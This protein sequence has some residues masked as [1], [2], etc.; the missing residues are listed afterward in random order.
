M[1]ALTA[2]CVAG[3]PK[4]III[5]PGVTMPL[6]NL[7]GVSSR[8]SNYSAWLSL[9]GRGLDTAL[10]YGDATQQAVAAA[11]SA[12]TV[13]RSEIFVTSKVPCCHSFPIPGLSHDC[14]TPEFNGTALHSIQE[15]VAILGKLD[16][17]LLHWPCSTLEGTLAAYADLEKALE[18][19]LTRAI[20]VSNFNATTLAAMLPKVKTQPAVNQCGHSVGAHNA[21]HNP[22]LGGDDATVAF[23]AA[24]NIAY[25]AYSPLGGLN[26]LDI[27]NNPTVKRIATAHSVSPAQVALRWLIQQDPPISIVTAADTPE[28]CAED[29]DLF[30][31]ELTAAEMATL[32]AL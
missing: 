24:H 8:P 10:T 23:C 20:G 13:K 14:G 21:S 17:V 15:D 30:S 11:L 29:M 28:Y 7:G 4:S 16:L 5:A 22:T 31:F 12:T 1:F 9:G 3:V 6:A 18:L 32:A 2:M 19:G 26:G 25:S 27:F